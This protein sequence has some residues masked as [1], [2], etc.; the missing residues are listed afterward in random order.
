[1]VIDDFNVHGV[2]GDHQWVFA[3]R[4]FAEGPAEANAPPIINADAVLVVAVAAQ[5]LEAVG[6][7]VAQFHQPGGSVQL[8]Q[9]L[10]RLTFERLEFLDALSSG[11]IGAAL[12]RI[13]LDR[14][15]VYYVLRI[16]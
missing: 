15:G 2:A 3:G 10:N 16:A 7:R 14:H 4:V 1:M 12:I 11:E 8:G 6:R 9:P 5:R 13:A